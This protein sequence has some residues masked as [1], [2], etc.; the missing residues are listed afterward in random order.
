V[1]EELRTEFG[2]GFAEFVKFIG[3]AVELKAKEL[4]KGKGFFDTRTY[5]FEVF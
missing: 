3:R 5:V 4:G 2:K 1:C